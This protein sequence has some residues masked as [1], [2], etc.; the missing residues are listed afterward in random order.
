[1][2]R[3]CFTVALIACFFAATVAGCGS[4]ED[5]IE[6][7]PKPSARIL[8]ASV[9][10]LSL[11]S[12]DL[13]FDIEIANPYGVSLPLMDLT[14]T[15]GSGHQQLLTGS[16][17]PS[18][19]V[20]AN[21][22]SVMQLPARLDLGAVTKTLTSVKPGAVV[23]YYAEINVIVDAPLLGE[24]SLPLKRKGEIPIPAIPE[25]TLASFDVAELSLD[26]VSATANLRI[27][28]TNQFQIDFSRLGL[29]LALGGKR[30]ADVRLR[31]SSKLTPGQ[32]AIVEIPISIAPAAIG[33]GLVNLL[34]G[35]DAGYNMS[36]RLDVTTRFGPLAMPFSQNGET[37]VRR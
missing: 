14:Y 30:V 21:S 17:K 28:N 22:S 10:D 16:L 18:G 13:V 8:G 27:K 35:S 36:G 26:R 5:V 19:S 34:S 37:A 12:L 33:A 31:N 2:Q 7:A 11:R 4:L 24:M 1:V 25:I 15:I 29:N 9:R 23:P 6:S 20:P 3:R 32:V